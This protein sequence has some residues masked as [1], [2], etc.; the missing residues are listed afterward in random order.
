MSL[1]EIGWGACWLISC[2]RWVSW[3]NNRLLDLS[4]VFRI[5]ISKSSKWFDFC[6]DLE[7][8]ESLGLGVNLSKYIGFNV[9]L[10]RHA[11]GVAL[12][13]V[14]V[15]CLVNLLPAWI[16]WWW[17]VLIDTTLEMEDNL[18]K[19]KKAAR[20]ICMSLLASVRGDASGDVGGG[21]VGREL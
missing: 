8:M 19:K 7:N 3:H 21:G 11:A 10:R 6:I 5:K 14:R 4:L 9:S 13:D 1:S 2:R 17:P 15:G 16:S 12:D 20:S 18:L